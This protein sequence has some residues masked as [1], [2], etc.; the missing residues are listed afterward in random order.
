ME[1]PERQRPEIRTEPPTERV[2]VYSG[3]ELAGDGLMKIPFLRALRR[4]YPKAHITWLSGKGA[5]VYA[6]PL[7]EITAGLIDE[8]IDTERFGRRY[9]ELFGN[10]LPGRAFDLVIDTQ[11]RLLTTLILRRVP[12]RIFVSGGLG[13]RLSDR[14]PGRR[15]KPPSMVGQLLDL[16]EAASGRA[17]APGGRLTLAPALRLRA[18]AVLPEGPLYIGLAPGA[19]GKHK[20]WPRARFVELAARQAARGRCPVFVLGPDEAAWF[21][22]LRAAVP[23]ARFPLQEEAGVQEGIGG[24]ASIAFTVALAERFTAAVAND[25]GAGHMFAAADCPLVSLFGPTRAEKFAPL[26]SR[27]RV[28]RARDFGTTAMGAIP[29]AAV[30][31]ALD[32]LLAES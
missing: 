14:R 5:T 15:T 4:A 6:G 27:A 1:T 26:V 3:G 8:V 18:R 12:H 23:K 2:L 9:L 21:E 22:E 30:E 7:R 16:V 31:T 11:R 28:I 20:C 32:S 24:A 17:A 19:G 10:P 13:Y 25:A 29:L